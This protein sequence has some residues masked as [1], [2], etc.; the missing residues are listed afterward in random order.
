MYTTSSGKN[1]KLVNVL[2]MYRPTSS[3]NF[4]DIVEDKTIYDHSRTEA[5]FDP[6]EI[7]GRLS[8]WSNDPATIE[9]D[10]D[11]NAVSVEDIL[12]NS[13]V[14]EM[15]RLSQSRHAG[16]STSIRSGLPSKFSTSQYSIRSDNISCASADFR[17][18]EEVMNTTYV[19]N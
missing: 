13:I 17:P 19:F 10:I 14:H 15:R 5:T 9:P 7:S 16:L 12:G 3:I 11:P 18:A 8:A 4:S 2:E 6:A 1:E